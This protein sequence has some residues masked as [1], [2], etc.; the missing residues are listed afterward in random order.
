MRPDLNLPSALSADYPTVT[1]AY[2]DALQDA[3]VAAARTAFEV[4]FDA[5]DIKS[6]HGYLINELLACRQREGR[7]G[8]SFD[9]RTRFLLEVIDRIHGTLGND[10]PVFVRL[11][12]YDA[13]P[14]PYGWGVSEHDYATPDLTEPKKLIALL[15]QRGVRMIN[16]T[17][18]NP[19]Y[20]P[21]FGRPFNEPVV[22]GYASP[23]HPL[24]GVSR[25]IRLT[26]EV[27]QAFD[28]VAIV[29]TGYSWL[30][31]VMPH[32][33]AAAK[34]AGKAKVIGAGRL[35][36]AYPD[37]ARDIVHKGRLDP[38]KVCVGCSAC[39]QIMR[40]GGK[41]GCVV[42]DN[43]VYGPIFRRG[44]MGNREHLARLAAA[45][46]QCQ[47]PTCQLAC[48]A[49]IEIPKFIRLFL[50][51][52]DEAAYAVIRRSNVFPE[53]CA[54][55]C[56]VEQQCQGGC[57]Q[58]FIGDA[59]LPIA[60]IQRYLAA[61]A[62][63]KGWSRL[64][65]PRKCSGR[66][67][68]VVGAGP[69]GLAAAA[70]LLEQGHKVAVFDKAAELG[71]IVRSMIPSD[72][73]ETAL[74]DEV[75]AVFKD[76][77]KDRLTLRLGEAI[78]AEFD[79]DAIIAE[80]FDAVFIGAG[81]P[82]S[83]ETGHTRVNG[84]Y[85]AGQFLNAAKRGEPVAVAG[86]RVAIVGGGNTAMDAAL[87]AARCGAKDVYVV[88]RRSFR[89]M[90]AWAAE[91]DRALAAGVHFLIL[92]AVQ[93]FRHDNGGLRGLRL[94]PTTLGEPDAS[95][96]R[97]PEPVPSSAYELAMDVVV[98]AIG[99]KADDGLTDVLCG[100]EIENGLVL[101]QPNSCATSRVGVFAGGDI[102][103]GPSTVVTAVAD[104][105]KAAAEID[106]FLKQK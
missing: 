29:G 67:I 20:N 74:S 6:C 46:T 18:A 33:A 48:P 10:K 63:R 87:T 65:I 72:R 50:D 78:R 15:R 52:N 69:A 37:F 26:G 91:R 79:L 90:P 57:L 8:G 80:S 41:A 106:T 45:C 30:R 40:D 58:H 53:V 28:D 61:Q 60:D 27:Q 93:G 43:A 83:V 99:Q 17:I 12:I 71:G 66:K 56:P 81:L 84:V 62:N 47:E 100:V 13:I 98:E 75:A 77:G 34:A 97:R 19:Y 54:W 9:N 59:A 24:Q 88:Y 21:H 4:G 64:Q 102:V 85:T 22:G 44:R 38:E 32:V 101:T 2:L 39:T 49:G 105:M 23:E 86:K 89:E 70:V 14:F 55:L 11:G 5:V 104:G 3:Y 68:A 73:Q 25:L 51:G 35:A 103:R 42:R 1:D 36:F 92:T 96:R 76:V 31:T 16:V 94:C 7:Y 82:K 95:G